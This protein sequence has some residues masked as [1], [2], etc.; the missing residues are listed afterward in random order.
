MCPAN[1]FLPDDSPETY[2][3]APLSVQVV[4]MKQEDEA[5]AAIVELVDSILN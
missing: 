5:L 1:S 3:D 4:A 2:Q